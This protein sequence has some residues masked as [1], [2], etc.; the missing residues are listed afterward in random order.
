MA[1]IER[2]F[3][4]R[5]FFMATAAA[6]VSTAA[7]SQDKPHLSGDVDA[8]SHIWTNDTA[9]YP[10]AN[11]QPAS[12]LIPP[13]FSAEELLA[14][15]RPLGV[16]RV[17]LI[18]HRPYF[19]VDNSYLADVMAAFPGVFSG[20]ACI[21]EQAADV[22]GEMR[23]LKRQGFRGFRIRP[24]EGGTTLWKESPGIRRMCETATSEG[25]AICPLVTPDHLGQVKELAD[26]WPELAIVVDHFGRVGQGG[27]FPEADV[28][29]L[30]RL[31][32]HKHVRVKVSAFYFLGRKRPPY[33]DL[34]PLIRMVRDAF[35]AERMMWG[36]D[37]PYQLGGENTYAA[38]LKLVREGLDFL[39][40]TERRALLKTTA[41]KVFFPA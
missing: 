32:K 36:S 4:R 8:H 20:V 40:E 41:E 27:D 6:A 19:G 15:A 35:G 23:R 21:D 17:V 10:L 14:I 9:K 29:A 11:G 28:R 5:G 39:S 13:T 22:A 1:G 34:A 31:A 7:M 37:C 33:D 16:S 2:P 26:A 18:Q 3:S 38:S 25:L 12:N 30:L 24:G